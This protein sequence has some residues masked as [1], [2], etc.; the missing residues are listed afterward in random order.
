MP[1]EHS[2]NT[3]GRSDR[4]EEEAERSAIGTLGFLPWPSGP[5]HLRNLPDV[6]AAP[7]GDRSRPPSLWTL[8]QFHKQLAQNATEVVQSDRMVGSSGDHE[9]QIM[10]ALQPVALQPD[11][12]AHQALD[13][14]SH[15]SMPHL[16]LDGDEEAA[17]SLI[18]GQ[19]LDAEQPQWAVGTFRKNPANLPSLIQTNRL[20]KTPV[21]HQALRRLRPLAR[22][23]LM[24]R[25]PAG[26][27]IR[28]RN[29]CFFLRRRLFG[30]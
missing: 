8:V 26:V 9:A 19:K 29:P 17:G 24:T 3:W 11:R 4:K 15:R 7:A 5:P 28:E 2:A 6:S 23:R 10:R 21:F 20:G 1:P 30:W 13:P 25:R 14:V 18:P 12:L 27:A 16:F 22:R